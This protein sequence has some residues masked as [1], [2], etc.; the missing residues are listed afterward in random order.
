MGDWP[1][2]IFVCPR[3][4]RSPHKLPRSC[5]SCWIPTEAVE[6][7]P[8]G[9]VPPADR[10][11]QIEVMARAIAHDNGGEW[12]S[13]RDRENAVAVLDALAAVS[14]AA[15]GGDPNDPIEDMRPG[16]PCH[17]PLAAAPPRPCDCERLQ[18]QV[19]NLTSYIE[20]ICDEANAIVPVSTLEGM[21]RTRDAYRDEIIE[22]KRQISLVPPALWAAAQGKPHGE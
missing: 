13:Q 20:D 1:K 17:A 12:V 14:C 5:P 9:S 8:A 19:D 10:E 15:C 2:T 7:V 21:G 6:V 22:L 3:C 16:V 4:G 18:M 11:A